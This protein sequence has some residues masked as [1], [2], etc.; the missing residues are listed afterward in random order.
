MGTVTKRGKNSWR[1]ATQY[2]TAHGWEWMRLTLHMD[3]ELPESV[4]KRDAERELKKLE[5]RL[6]AEQDDE[7]RLTVRSWSQQWIE[8]HVRPDCSPVTVHNYQHLLN[9]RILP[10]L[11]DVPLED[12]TPAL[13]TDWMISLR[14][15]PRKTTRKPDEQLAH[16]RAK[17][18]KLISDAQASRPLSASTIQHYYT[19]M[20]AM[21]STAVR[22]GYLEHNPM[23]RVKRP[24]TR[25][26]EVKTM[27]EMDAV[28]LIADLESCPNRQLRLAVLLA[29][30]CGLRLGEVGALRYQ[31]V[32]WDAGTL[33]IRAAHKYTP[34]AGSFEDTT[35]TAASDRLITLP[36]TMVTILREAMWDDV[37]QS[38]INPKWKQAR[39]AVCYIVHARDGTQLHHDTPSKWWRE[40]A[41]AHG[42]PGLR[43][44]DLRHAHASILVSH[45]IDVAAVASRMGHGDATVTL[46][47][48]AHAL[49]RR[50][51][52]AALTLDHI[53]Q[54]GQSQS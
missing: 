53:L 47:T 6:A 33:R 54:S 40:Y 19:C 1:I 20:E 14:S 25:K 49:E 11:G 26:A 28:V 42:Y 9:S 7:E 32:D 8:K 27:S 35:K 43:F 50:D 16:P 52:A 29:L 13:L 39:P 12:L 37:E 34:E 18:E 41:D 4:Q 44:H 2:K 45:S 48:Y 36:P 46:R 38:E 23:E 17:S 22:M 3:P 15:A 21:L 24:K 51:T 30:T 31:D 5:K 10:K